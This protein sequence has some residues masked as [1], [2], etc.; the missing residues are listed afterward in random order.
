MRKLPIVVF[1]LLLSLKSYAITTDRPNIN[2]GVELLSGG[3]VSDAFE[4]GANDLVSA[5]NGLGIPGLISGE[6]KETGGAGLTAGL[7]FPKKNDYEFGFQT[8][9]GLGPIITQD[10]KNGSFVWLP[11]GQSFGRGQS[12]VTTSSTYMK[13][14]F[15][16]AKLYSLSKNVKLRLCAKAGLAKININQKLETTGSA[17]S[18]I[19]LL[20]LDIH[21]EENESASGAA[22]EISPSL[23]LPF[24]STELEAGLKYAHYPTKSQSDQIYKYDWNPVGLF[25]GMRF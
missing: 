17:G 20:N 19:S 6:T 10:Y 24:G 16:G 11:T 8:G 12:R 18:L 23:I 13:F 1:S 15:E 9:F 7:T 22:W 4:N 14:L 21:N 3:G 5:I 25:I 2:F